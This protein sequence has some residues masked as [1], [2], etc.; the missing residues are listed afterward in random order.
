MKIAVIGSGYVGLV[1]AACFAEI[2]HEVIS[3]DNDHAKVNALRN[4]EVPI[5][6]QFLPE[7]LAKHRGKGLKFST[8]VGD[9]TAWADAVFITVGTPQSATG[10]ADL[11][12]VEAVAHE[13]ATAIHGS[14]LVVEKSTVPVRTCEAIRKVLQ[15][16]GA[17]ADLFSVASNPE[18]LREGS[19]VLDF[20][21]PDR[22]VIGVDTE[23]SRGLMEQIYWPLTSGEYYK[24]SDALGAGPRFSECA[25]LIVTSPKS[26]ELIK[27]ASNAFL[28]MKISFINAVANIAES[29]GADIDEIRA[30][31]GADS[32]IGNRFLNAGVGYGGSCFP[33]DVQAFHAV[34]QECGYRFG[35][36]NEVIE[37]NAEQRR[38]FILKVRSAVWTL[39]G[40][41]L[42]VLGAAFKGGTD[43][44]RE[45][46]AIAIVDELLAQGSSVRLF[47]PAALP[48][49]KAV[50]G[51]SVQYASDA[52]DAATGTD[53]LLILTEW[54]EFAQLD[55]ERL[56]KAMKFPIIVDG[57]NLYRPSFMAKAGFAYHS[58]G[59]PE[60]AAEK[61]A[62][63]VR[64][65][66]WIYVNKSG[67]AS[68]D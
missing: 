2:G 38:R 40:K 39:R 54:P 44:I 45:S 4:G 27:H 56:R 22:I 19:A 57:R 24:R 7:L 47:D 62:Q 68:A 31:I 35:L 26:A 23:F 16:C 42:A 5:H 3:V 30:G 51:D 37:I 43:D 41:T 25:P 21:H 46:P 59:R 28:A 1:S 61:S 17:P 55:L 36:L 6:E 8:S 66:D 15:L 33:K 65:D 10:E 53:A 60:L 50:L 14:K 18:F 13:I 9:A 32:R 67:A 20:L 58:I 11:S 29:V 52:Y 34:A 63:G 64:R 49:A 48:K 12:Y